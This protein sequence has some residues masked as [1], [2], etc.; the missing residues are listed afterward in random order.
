MNIH[1]Q[2]QIHIHTRSKGIPSSYSSRPGGFRFLELPEHHPVSRHGHTHTHRPSSLPLPV[3]SPAR[4]KSRSPLANHVHI[5]LAHSQYVSITRRSGIQTRQNQQNTPTNHNEM[6]P[7]K[8]KRFTTTHPLEQSSRVESGYTGG[9]SRVSRDLSK[10][11]IA[12][13]AVIS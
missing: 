8:R 10:T 4:R 7:R 11:R 12:W 3:Y 5:V 6:S 13:L 9:T 2:I 1:I